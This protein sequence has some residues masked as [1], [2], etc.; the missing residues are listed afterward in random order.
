MGTLGQSGFLSNITFQLNK[1]TKKKKRERERFV[2]KGG[3]T[4]SVEFLTE[5]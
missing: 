5:T 2:F 1:P 3:K 4:V